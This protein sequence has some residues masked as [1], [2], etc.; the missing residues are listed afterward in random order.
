MRAPSMLLLLAAALVISPVRG[1]DAPAQRS[2]VIAT[3]A[4]WRPP[5]GTADRQA[6]DRLLALS[7]DLRQ[8]ITAAG[9]FVFNRNVAFIRHDLNGDGRPEAF[10]LLS[11][12]IFCGSVGCPANILTQHEGEW[13]LVA[14]FEAD[15]SG[16]LL[17]MRRRT[18]GWHDFRSLYDQMWV[19]DA[20]APIG[21]S[22]RYGP[23]RPYDACEDQVFAPER[24]RAAGRAL[25]PCG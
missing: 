16:R 3:S 23:L 6:F 10:I 9:D 5:A 15:R 1:A 25:P 13:R 24:E 19:S 7:P 2:E 11:H 17:I 18:Q 8:A 20:A 22:V 14:D 4:R 12:G 21:V